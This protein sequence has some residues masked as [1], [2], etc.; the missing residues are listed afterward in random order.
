MYAIGVGNF[1]TG[2]NID[3]LY[4]IASKPTASHVYMVSDFNALSSLVHEISFK[5]CVV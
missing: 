1:S 5:A 4:E 3:Q 2:L